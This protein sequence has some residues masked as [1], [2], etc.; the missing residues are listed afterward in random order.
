MGRKN[1][2]WEG[3]TFEDQGHEGNHRRL[4]FGDDF[5][6]AFMVPAGVLAFHRR[7]RNRWAPGT[8]KDVSHSLG[9]DESQP[10]SPSS[11]QICGRGS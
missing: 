11:S 2:A 1:T 3:L 10:H 4:H 9:A 7:S 8:P 5:S 6:V